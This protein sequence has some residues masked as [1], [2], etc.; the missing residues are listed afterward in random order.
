[1][2]IEGNTGPY[3]QYI[4]ARA[5][6]II[7]KAGIF[8]GNFE[9]FREPNDYEKNVIRQI[10]LFPLI[11]EE[12]A[13]TLFIK[14]LVNYTHQLALCFNDFYEKCQ[15]ISSNEKET[16]YRLAIVAAFKQTLNNCLYLLGLPIIE[17]M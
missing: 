4:F 10:A 2:K 7:E 9:V 3:L 14:K 5:C 1:M 8:N 11:V 12:V 15:V 13:K 16:N 17:E 6:R